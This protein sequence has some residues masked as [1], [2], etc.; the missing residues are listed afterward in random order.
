VIKK[1]HEHEEE[2]FSIPVLKSKLENRK[3]AA[4]TNPLTIDPQSELMEGFY[5]GS[6]DSWHNSS[7]G[8]SYSLMN[9][10]LDSVCAVILGFLL[11]CLLLHDFFFAC[12]SLHH[13]L[14]LSFL[15]V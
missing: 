8:G 13:V 14:L 7:G 1:K 2:N 9:Y 5:R 10:N 6:A 15:N 11:S 12:S 3:K 4:A